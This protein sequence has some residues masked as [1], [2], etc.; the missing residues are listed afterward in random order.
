MYVN[1]A[2]T[3]FS[4]I[5]SGRENEVYAISCV[6]SGILPERGMTF[7]IA[8]GLFGISYSKLPMSLLPVMFPHEL[9]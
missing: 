7:V 4:D 8:C 6:R 9:K 5:E 2:F 3:P 1:E